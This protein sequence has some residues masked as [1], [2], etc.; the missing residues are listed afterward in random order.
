MNVGLRMY[1]YCYSSLSAIY[2]KALLSRKSN[3]LSYERLSTRTR[4]EEEVEDNSEMAYCTPEVNLSLSTLLLLNPNYVSHT[5]PNDFFITEAVYDTICL[6]SV[7]QDL[8][9]RTNPPSQNSGLS[10]EIKLTS[11]PL[12]SSSVPIVKLPWTVTEN[13]C[14]PRI[15]T[16]FPNE[17]TSMASE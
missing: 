2:A 3:S 4:F 8:L 17:K 16:V 7:Q 12:T 10:R 5:A 9:T 15:D 13:A 6:P 1:K 14:A 11:C